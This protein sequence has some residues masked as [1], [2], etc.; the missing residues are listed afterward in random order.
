MPGQAS[1]HLIDQL[2]PMTRSVIGHPY[3]YG[4]AAVICWV[5]S[6]CSFLMANP[7][8]LGWLAIAGGLGIIAS[9]ITAI[10]MIAVKRAKRAI[11]ES[12]SKGA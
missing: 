11:A 8:K 7:A 12:T 9:I 10:M 3:R 2:D 4:L 1:E 6:F 5:F